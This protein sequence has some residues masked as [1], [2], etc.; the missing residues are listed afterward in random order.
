M[1]EKWLEFTALFGDA[2]LE[3]LV[4]EYTVTITLKK[5]G[6]ERIKDMLKNSCLKVED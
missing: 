1:E 6:V 3:L 2:F 4:D 5:N